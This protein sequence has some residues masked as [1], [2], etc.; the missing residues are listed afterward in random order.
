MPWRR[1]TTWTACIAGR[2]AWP[3]DRAQA[4][5]LVRSTY[6][7]ALR[8]QKSYRPGTSLK[9]WLFAIMHDRFNGDRADALG[10]AGDG[11]H[12][13]HEIV[14]EE[15]LGPGATALD[16]IPRQEVIE[17][18]DGLPPAH[19]EVVLLVDVEGLT[20][21]ET[22]DVLGVSRGTV[23]SRLRCA[24]SRLQKA[25][26]AHARDWG[27]ARGRAA[28]SESPE[29]SD[30]MGDIEHDCDAGFAEFTHR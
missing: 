23:M 5:K 14:G 7:R 9:A 1:S 13:L 17:V 22:A 29:E 6:V 8:H 24:R 12:E 10:P 26:V 4:E 19:R 21:G 2:C 18:V 16:R 30:R 28:R 25:L 11:E 3:G 15:G 27:V 20:Y